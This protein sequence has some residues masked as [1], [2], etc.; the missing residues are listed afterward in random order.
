MVQVLLGGWVRPVLCCAVLC[1]PLLNKE[2]ACPSHPAVCSRY[3]FSPISIYLH[4]V[5]LLSYTKKR[6]EL[7][8]HIPSH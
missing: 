4:T 2:A 6:D 5:Y 3:I 7:D 8:S 1:L